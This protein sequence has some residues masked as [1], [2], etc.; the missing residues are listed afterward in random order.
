[1]IQIRQLENQWVIPVRVTP[2]GGRDCIVP[3]QDGDVSIRVKVSTPPEDGK[4]NLAVIRLLADVLE[5]PKS[6]ISVLRGQQSREK[7]IALS[8]HN[9]GDAI[10]LMKQLSRVIQGPVEYKQ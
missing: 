4:A 10:A 6:R 5:I 7:Q 2:R 3:Y 8:L 1:M 9:Q